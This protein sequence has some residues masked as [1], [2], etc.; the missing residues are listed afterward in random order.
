MGRIP[1]I[2]V[3]R[4]LSVGGRD[5]VVSALPCGI[6]RREI[7][8]L[9]IRLESGELLD[10]DNFDQALRH[11]AASVSVADPAL[12]A[13]DLDDGLLISDVSILF[14]AVVEVSGL[15]RRAAEDSPEGEAESPSS[16]SSS[17][18][19]STGSSSRR[20]GGRSGTSRQ[21]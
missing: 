19:S 1:F 6:L 18:G 14:R 7:L 15:T 4:K 20:Q 16:P 10:G 2:P 9:A 12:T 13:Q 5:F 3:S 17:G 8:P 11:C 21:S